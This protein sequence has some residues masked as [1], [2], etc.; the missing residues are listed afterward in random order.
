MINKLHYKRSRTARKKSGEKNFTN[1]SYRKLK[2]PLNWQ[3]FKFAREKKKKK[4]KWIQINKSCFEFSGMFTRY[5]ITNAVPVNVYIIAYEIQFHF[6][7][8]CIHRVN[9]NLINANIVSKR[10][11]HEFTQFFFSLSQMERKI[12]KKERKKYILLSSSAAS[13]SLFGK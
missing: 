7:A 9:N 3:R 12:W 4:K 10:W 1:A 6:L 2:S 11:I 13:F 8:I 5:C